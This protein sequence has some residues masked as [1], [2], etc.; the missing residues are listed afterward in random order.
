MRTRTPLSRLCAALALALTVTTAIAA[1]A[2]ADERPS[3]GVPYTGT[4]YD[5]GTATPLSG[6]QP[7][8]DQLA[9]QITS[10]TDRMLRDLA[11]HRAQLPYSAD[12]YAVTTGSPRL[13][14]YPRP[15]SEPASTQYAT[16][17][18]QAGRSH[19]PVTY[20][21]AARRPNNRE[22]DT[23]W[24][25]FS[26]RGPIVVSVRALQR[27][28]ATGCLVRPAS[29]GVHTR[30]HDGTC[31]FALRRPANLSVEFTPQGG[32]VVAHP[33]LLFANPL[34]RDVPSPDDE[35]VLYFGPGVHRIGPNVQLHD[36]ET[37]YLA[38]GAW[39]EGTFVGVDVDNVV[40]KGRGVL[41][42]L[43]LD[44]GNQ[45]EN[46]KQPGFVDIRCDNQGDPA[47]TC[48]TNPTSSNVLI[49]GLT[50]V[51]GPRLNVRALSSYTTVRNVKMIGWWI[52]TDGIVAGNKSLVE[53]NFVKVNEDSLKLFWGDSVVR[54]NVVW[55]LE[56]GAPFMLSWNIEQD[57]ANFHVYDDDVI[58]VEQYNAP[59]QGVFDA[60]HA[61]AGRLQRYLF[62]RIR[63]EDATYRLFYLNIEHNRWYDPALG[64]GSF[65]ELVFRDITAPP[66]SAFTL[67]SVVNG[68]D[69]EHGFR[70]VDLVD[71]RMGD[72][73]LT[74][75]GAANLQLDPEATSQIRVLAGPHCGGAR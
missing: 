9:G 26:F 74:T 38:G 45:A 19:D 64:Y 25:S 37:V 48:A 54:D 73:C 68:I 71:V 30:Y 33:M 46:K 16:T 13:V 59:T 57:S 42:G 41:D 58:H 49:D 69:P 36:N 18:V 1:P 75:A 31:T 24:S 53:H 29:A 35:N 10:S 50:L 70:N 17:V 61:G 3:A 44:T 5:L 62:E 40:I 56:N 72:A 55:Q 12:D 15:D 27:T 14:T 28:D 47:R 43:F 34:E 11:A 22:K 60:R 52:N 23:S 21:R 65:S 51:D 4:R 67:P 7:E 39:V 32:P 8:V 66:A 6:P 20:T 63:I 2:T